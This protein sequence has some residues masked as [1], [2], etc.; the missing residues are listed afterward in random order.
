MMTWR[1]AKASIFRLELLDLS[2]REKMTPE[3]QTADNSKRQLEPLLRM[4]QV[5]NYVVLVAVLLS[6]YLV[7]VQECAASVP[8]AAR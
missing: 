3:Q 8:P 7:L 6:Q 2:F 1:Q 5:Q 4:V